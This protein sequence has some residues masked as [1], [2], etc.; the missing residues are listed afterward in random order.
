[1][2]RRFSPAPSSCWGAG[3]P[4]ATVST[5]RGAGADPSTLDIIPAGEVPARA[6]MPGWWTPAGASRQ[7]PVAAVRSN[8]PKWGG[9]GYCF[10][11][12]Q[13]GGVSHGR[14]H[15]Y[16]RYD[17]FPTMLRWTRPRIHGRGGGGP[18]GHHRDVSRCPF[19][20]SPTSSRWKPSWQRFAASIG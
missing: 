6:L 10:D 4:S 7:P 14:D 9:E 16:G 1:V 15:G 3:F 8:W 19:G 17:L 18:V 12:L 11:P 2:T 13:Q 5:P 20:Q